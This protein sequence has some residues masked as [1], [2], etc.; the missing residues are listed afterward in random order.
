MN[1]AS[2]SS[3]NDN[4]LGQLIADGNEM[5]MV[6]YRNRYDKKIYQRAYRRLHCAE[7]TEWVVAEV[8]RKTFSKASEWTGLGVFPAWV[9]SIARFQIAEVA[10]NESRNKRLRPFHFVEKQQ[11]PDN[12]YD[13]I[14]HVASNTPDALD[15]IVLEEESQ[16][17]ESAI[18]DALLKLTRVQRVSIVLTVEGY[19]PE[20]IARVLRKS[21]CAM[22]AI[23]DRARRKIR[24]LLAD[25]LIEQ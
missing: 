10:R 8:F 1:Y 17:L 15:E 18:N 19:E 3:M 11:D 22:L 7:K 14:D 5:A 13:P 12:D 16:Q 21:K 6:E 9:S 25:Y 2:L 20:E 23:R 4:A 24:V